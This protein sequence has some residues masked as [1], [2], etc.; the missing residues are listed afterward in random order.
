MSFLNYPG[1][2]RRRERFKNE[3]RRFDTEYNGNYLSK[4]RP[5][6]FAQVFKHQWQ[7][8]GKPNVDACRYEELSEKPTHLFTP[9]ASKATKYSITESQSAMKE[10]KSRRNKNLDLKFLNTSRINRNGTIEDNIKWKVE[11]VAS[12]PDSAL[13][14][15]KPKSH[16]NVSHSCPF[17]PTT[18]NKKH[19]FAN[20]PKWYTERGTMIRKS[21]RYDY[22]YVVTSIRKKYN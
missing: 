6:L 7:I 10:T 13:L 12:R 1:Y 9:Y 4:T 14:T 17:K 19:Q 20:Q 11:N 3:K 8:P 15:Q 18:E 16:C 22:N 5:V 2:V 21:N